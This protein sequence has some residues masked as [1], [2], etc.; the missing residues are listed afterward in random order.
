M[1]ILIVSLASLILAGGSF[2]PTASSPPPAVPAEITTWFATRGPLEVERTIASDPSWNH[3]Q[4]IVW[5]AVTYSAPVPQMTYVLPDYDLKGGRSK[6]SVAP[7]DVLRSTNGY[8]ARVSGGGLVLDYMLCASRNA[9]G[10]VQGYDS[11]DQVEFLPSVADLPS[12]GVLNY[13]G[14]WMG[15]EGDSLVPLDLAAKYDVPVATPG[16]VVIEAMAKRKAEYAAIERVEGPVAGASGPSLLAPNAAELADWNA[17]VQRGLA[18][19]DAL[20]WSGDGPSSGGVVSRKSTPV[21]PIALGL[22]I[23][24]VGL[25]AL[26]FRARHREQIGQM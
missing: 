25:L 24:F 26:V 13:Q 3:S 10:V 1:N 22:G 19:P 11:L 21:L 16:T 15:I 9:D 14:R 20:A 2:V 7:R 5:A 6:A 18:I 12:A 8:C 4:P 23:V 17:Q